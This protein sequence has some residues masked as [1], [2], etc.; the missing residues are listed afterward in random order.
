MMPSSFLLRRQVR[1]ARQRNR[2]TL[3]DTSATS[4][5]LAATDS[6]TTASSS[7]NFDIEAVKL[8]HSRKVWPGSETS[9]EVSKAGRPFAVRAIDRDIPGRDRSS[10]AQ[11]RTVMTWLHAGGRNKELTIFVFSCLASA[12]AVRASAP[13]SL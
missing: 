5:T 11:L 3:F 10:I 7:I 1:N 4:S 2:H 8:A 9:Q 6:R 13:K 12:P